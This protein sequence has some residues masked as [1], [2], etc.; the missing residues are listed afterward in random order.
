MAILGGLTGDAAATAHHVAASERIA[1]EIRSPVLRL[2]TAEVAVEYMAGV[3]EWRPA[4]ALAE[5]TIPA[6]RMLGQHTLLPRLLVW[7][8][9]IH[10]GLGDLDRAREHVEEAWALSGAAQADSGRP[11]DVHAVVPAHMGMAGYLVTVG[12]HQRALEVGEAGL[13]IADR[14]GYVAWAIYRLLPFVIE[15]ALWLRDYERAARYSA[16]LRRDALAL[17]HALGLAWADTTDALLA[18]LTGPAD[19][20]ATLLRDAAAELEAVPFVFDAARLRRMV[21]HAL[22]DAGDREGAARELRRAHDVFARL[23][24]EREM[25]G[26]REQLRKLGVRPPVRAPAF[27]TGALSGREVEIARLVSARKSNKEIA[28]ALGISART[29]S[30]HVSNIFDK[31]GVCSRG[32]LADVVRAE[33]IG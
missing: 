33:G 4:L 17:G 26:T 31:V 9:L 16:R 11:L 10:R 22:C 28:A 25:H 5:R 20:A 23:G 24:A 1:D 2:W 8:G 7:A 19:R 27:G 3:G 15:A 14:T 21:A 18:Y 13:V 30:T 29:V 6:A 32:E 12:E